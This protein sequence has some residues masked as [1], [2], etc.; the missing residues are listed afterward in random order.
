MSDIIDAK[1][2]Q[3]VSEFAAKLVV[4][5]WQ[6]NCEVHGRHNDFILHAKPG[7]TTQIVLLPWNEK[8]KRSYLER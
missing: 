8:Q 2:G 1:P 5:A 6:Q 7:D 3:N 4:L